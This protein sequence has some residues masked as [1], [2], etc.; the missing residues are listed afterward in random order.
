MENQNKKS[1]HLLAAGDHVQEAL[2]VIEDLQNLSYSRVAGEDGFTLADSRCLLD[3]AAAH[4]YD[5]RSEIF[6]L[7]AC[8]ANDGGKA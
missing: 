3:K 2:N 8:E 7:A 6:Q 1:N 4:L 5:A